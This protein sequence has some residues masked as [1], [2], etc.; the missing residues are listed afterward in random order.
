VRRIGQAGWIGALTVALV[1]GVA[2]AQSPDESA[3]P[4]AMASNGV[5]VP[6][7]EIA[8]L[9]CRGMAEALRR[10]D[11][12]NY[13]GSEQVPMGHRDWPIF[14]YEDRLARAHYTECML[15]D[16]ALGDPGAAFSFGFE[17]Q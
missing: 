4:R 2:R 12:S 16:Q 8:G 9:D 17:T 13:R 5:V 15:R 7:P 1:L 10:I 14:D 6:M 11:L 3:V